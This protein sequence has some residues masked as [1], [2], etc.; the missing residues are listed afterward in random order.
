MQHAVEALGEGELSGIG[1]RLVAE[2]QHAVLI[3]AGAQFGQGVRVVQLHEVDRCDFSG[4][5]RTQRTE[6]RLQWLL[7]ILVR[8]RARGLRKL[9]SA[10]GWRD[11]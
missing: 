11:W 2:H 10:C 3:H 4:E 9:P 5:L 1:E 7:L 6:D 8:D